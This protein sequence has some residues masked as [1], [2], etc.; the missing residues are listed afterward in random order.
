MRNPAKKQCRCQRHVSYLGHGCDP[1]L[2]GSSYLCSVQLVGPS[3]YG[4]GGCVWLDWRPHGAIPEKGTRRLMSKD[5]R[6]GLLRTDRLAGPAMRVRVSISARTCSN[7]AG[8]EARSTVRRANPF[9]RA[10]A[11]GGGQR[12]AARRSH[13]FAALAYAIL[14]FLTL[15]WRR[16]LPLCA[17][18]ACITSQVVNPAVAWAASG[19]LAAE[20]LASAPEGL[21]LPPD[22]R[23]NG[24]GFTAHVVGYRFTPQF[25]TG[26]TMRRAASG[27]VFL[28]FGLTCT[29]TSL[30]ARLLVGGHAKMLPGEADY[31]G[32]VPTYYLA[33]IPQKATDVA[34]ELS[35]D[36]FS[37]EFSFTKGQREG[38]QPPA[39]YD[40]ADSWELTDAPDAQATLT[41]TGPKG[42]VEE[43]ANQVLDISASLTYF[44]P[45]TGAVPATSSS[46]WL[47]VTGT[48]L[49]YFVGSG[50]GDPGFSY[51]YTRPLR[52]PDVTLAL[53]RRAPVAARTTG[54]SVSGQLFAGSY[55]WQVPAG[56]QVATL[57]LSLPPVAPSGPGPSIPTGWRATASAGPVQ[58]NFSSAYQAPPSTAATSA[59]TSSNTSPNQT[60]PSSGGHVAA[61]PSGRHT[62]GPV[63]WTWLVLAAA[64]LIVSVSFALR[65]RRLLLAWVPGAARAGGAHDK[66]LR[67]SDGRSAGAANGVEH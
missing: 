44:L 26:K 62:T 58:M 37:Q 23:V 49:P 63:P 17:L 53:P 19:P 11:P 9:M 50:A 5:R 10:A 61:G 22:G 65:W 2:D 39:L 36:G 29:T 31:R 8:R 12:R 6:R 45:S 33:S 28:V 66:D 55:Y 67:D 18:A 51:G 24:D 32:L 3:S 54:A 7:G 34:L 43:R 30:A 64:G 13:H 15:R 57:R 16:R 40:S 20:V 42:R 4:A 14:T 21:R 35:K 1:R 41:V 25:G 47:V 48:V 59:G 56:T 27:Q 52:G 46:A 60:S 38:S